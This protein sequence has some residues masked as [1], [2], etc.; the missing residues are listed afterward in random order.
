MQG[1]FGRFGS[2]PTGRPRSL[3]PGDWNVAT[4]HSQRRGSSDVPSVG[5]AARQALGS[6]SGSFGRVRGKAWSR[7]DDLHLG[8]MIGMV[9]A[10]HDETVGRSV[11][12]R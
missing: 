5:F 11:I 2:A 9:R 12:S 4:R 3:I 10:W 1:R 8:V 7:A 6:T